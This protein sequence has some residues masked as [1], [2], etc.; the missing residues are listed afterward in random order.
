[1]CGI[2]GI[3][4][5]Q[6]PA[7]IERINES[8]WHRGP[9]EGGVFRE[10]DL[11]VGMRRL[12]IIDRSGGHQPMSSA[13]GRYVLVYNGEIFNAA[14][15]RNE[16]ERQGA[17]FVTDHS[18]TEVLLELLIREGDVALS[19]L[20][21]MFAFALVDRREQT[22]FC[23]RDR[24]GIKPFYF[25]RQGQR[26]AFA[27]EPKALLEL[28]WIEKAPNLQSL[29]HYFSLH[30]VP[31][32]ASAFAGIERLA[33][34]SSLRFDAHSGAVT[35]TRWW[36]PKFGGARRTSETELTERLGAAL[37]QAV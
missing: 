26:F 10:E 32:T 34:G 14:S 11:S 20:N 17:R 7:F 6:E 31:G 27:S 37:Q 28:P 9:D 8:L 15:L 5:R 29:Y 36:A 13:D 4:G 33:P 1:M 16:L 18:D 22:V 24:F 12:S 21:G 19:R 30:Y 35:I 23:A 3:V 2:V 25:H